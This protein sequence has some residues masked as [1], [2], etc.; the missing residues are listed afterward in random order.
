MQQRTVGK[1]I[2]IGA[3]LIIIC[4]SWLI[5][6]LVSPYCDTTNH[7]NRELAA[8]PVLTVDGYATYSK[9]YESYFNDHIP[10]RNGLISINSAIQY[11]AFN[12]SSDD[13]VIVG[14]DN[15]LF[16]SFVSDG[17]PV[18]CYMGTNLLT[19]DDLKAIADNCVSQRDF[20]AEQGKE[21]VIFIAPNK[22]RIYSEYMPEKYGEPADMYVALQIV[23]YLRENTDL[24]VVYPY[25]EL[26]ESKDKVD[27]NIYYLTDTHWN[28]V[29][30]YIGSVELLKELGIDMPSIDDDAI[31]ITKG[32]NTSGD[33][34]GMLNMNKFLK[35]TDSEYNVEGYNKHDMET[36]NDD[37]NTTKI[38]HS[39]GADERKLYVY[40]DSFASYMAPY[41]G[42]Q[43]NDTYMRYFGSYTYED[44][45]EQNPDVF[46]YE[47]VERYVT[48]LATFSIK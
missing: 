13:R 22:E 25:E 48:R 18:S 43:F 15:W 37:F 30:G 21:F 47:T 46:V 36:I 33:L 4:F 27:N 20:L 41:I 28:F 29:G 34:A 45:E 32:E 19:E 17:D 2:I 14:K 39:T 38:Y 11:F 1:D 9:D 5:W 44:F 24:R 42:S 10:F 23:N 40:R 35:N 7:E 12:K 8:R 31:S 16:Y 3:F 6:I 26:I